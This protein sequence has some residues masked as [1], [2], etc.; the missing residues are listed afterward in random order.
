M[1][2]LG[3]VEIGCEMKKIFLKT[4]SFAA[5]LFLIFAALISVSTTSFADDA[6]PTPL[7]ATAPNQSSHEAS[8]SKEHEGPRKPSKFVEEHHEGFEVVQVALVAA[9]VAIAI[10]LAYRA[11][12]RRG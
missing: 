9:A 1:V 7:T 8:E 5:S 11:G 10:G 6:T 12:K 3:T 4:G 2:N